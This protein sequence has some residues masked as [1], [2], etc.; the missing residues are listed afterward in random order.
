[1][2]P[3]LLNAPGLGQ[4]HRRHLQPRHRGWGTSGVNFTNILQAA[5]SCECVLRKFEFVMFWQK[6]ME[7][8]L[9]LK[10]WWHWLQ[11]LET[12]PWSK[13][14]MSVLIIEVGLTRQL[15][16]GPK[17]DVRKLLEKEG[18]LFYESTLLD[19]IYIKKET[20]GIKTKRSRRLEL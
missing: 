10:W 4:P 19:D 18:Y 7:K 17:Y 13:V 11:V 15:Y 14:N 9:L 3:S 6:E 12:I 8:K 16:T 2:L 1:M 20:F 5:L